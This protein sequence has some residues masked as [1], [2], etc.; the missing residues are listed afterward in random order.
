MI[1]RTTLLEEALE[2]WVDARRGVIDEARNIPAR[3]YGFSPA[4]GVRDVA[5]LLRHIMEVSMMMTEE[6]TRPETNLTRAPFSALIRPHAEVLA[7]LKTRQ[8]LLRALDRTLRDGLAR[9]RQAG[10]LHLLGPMVRFDG[11]PGTRLAWF[12]HGVEQEMY[13][14]GQLALY[15]RLLGI[16]PALTRKIRGG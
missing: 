6:L 15:Q 11:E 12:H 7:K 3:Q 1:S 8:E 16:E 4:P 5:E 9:F 10:E 14:R 13:H 2:S